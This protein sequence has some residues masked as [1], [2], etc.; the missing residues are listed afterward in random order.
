VRFVTPTGAATFWV[1]LALAL[2]TFGGGLALS[3]GYTAQQSRKIC[4]VDV[5]I[6][7][8]NQKMPEPTDPDT[9]QFRKA[10]HQYRLS[11]GC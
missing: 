2:V 11:L 3:I 6:D 5:L 10:L 4:G 1:T 8:R 9:A 7:D